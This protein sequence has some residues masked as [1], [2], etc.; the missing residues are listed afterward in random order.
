MH[1]LYHCALFWMV[2]LLRNRQL[3]YVLIFKYLKSFYLIRLQVAFLFQILKFGPL[4][5]Q[6]NILSLLNTLCKIF[7][8]LFL[9]LLLTIN[10]TFFHKLIIFKYISW[11]YLIEVTLDG[12]IWS[13]IIW[14]LFDWRFCWILFGLFTWNVGCV[15][16]IG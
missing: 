11:T 1:F 9:F 12:T 6:I 14:F 3:C 7:N 13:A 16:Y 8:K 10:L 4:F 15:L 2:L 5:D